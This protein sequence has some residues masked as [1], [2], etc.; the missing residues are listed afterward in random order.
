MIEIYEILKK[1]FNKNGFRL[2]VIGG[3]TRDYLLKK[4]LTDYDFVTDA[5]PSEMKTFL[6]NANYHFEKYGSVRLKVN[7]IKVDITT[8]RT[9]NNYLDKRH[10]D[11]ITFT[12]SLE[13]DYVRRDFTINA[14]YLDENYK[15]VDFCGGFND[16]NDKIIRFI[17]DPSTRIKEDPLRIIRAKRFADVLGF[18][19]EE[20]TLK[21][22]NELS[23]LTNELNP[24][25][26]KEEIRKG[27]KIKD[28][29]LL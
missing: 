2:Y 15:I 1:E 23:Y 4:E 19:I 6:S 18:K 21:A 5:M 28:D 9:E 10:P 12:K 16:L 3:T 29:N 14:I 13:E 7:G 27:Y 11:S 26:I 22:I 17:G 25:K 8:L 24:D 20:N